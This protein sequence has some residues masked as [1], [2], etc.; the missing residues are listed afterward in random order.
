[1]TELSQTNVHVTS[2]SL[3]AP[4]RLMQKDSHR[5]EML[6]LAVEVS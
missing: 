1:M 2:F 6:V 3:W 4:S 5:Y